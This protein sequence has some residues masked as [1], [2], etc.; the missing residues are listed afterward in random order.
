MRSNS[1]DGHEDGHE[2]EGE[3]IPTSPRQ[4][5]SIPPSSVDPQPNILQLSEGSRS[6]TSVSQ[7]CQI[8]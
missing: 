6:D 3:G 7:I 8:C 5:T 1:G 4:P 2:S